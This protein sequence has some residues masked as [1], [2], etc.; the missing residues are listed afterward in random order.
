M[1][2]DDFQT[3]LVIARTLNLHRAADE[4]K[5]TQSAMSKA[6]KRL[7]I[8]YEIP[9]LIRTSH[10]IALTQ[11]GETL[12]ERAAH[13]VNS[14]HDIDSEL[15]D[16]KTA[17]S[18][19][20][21]LGTSPGILDMVISPAIARFRNLQ[22]KV[23]FEVNVQVSQELFT[24]LRAGLLDLAIAPAPDKMPEGLNYDIVTEQAYYVVAR[25]DHPL[26]QRRIKISMLAS[27]EWILPPGDLQMRMWIDALFAEHRL[28]PLRVAIETR[29][30]PALLSPI[31]RQTNLLTVMTRNN[32]E[33]PMGAG[34]S[35]LKVPPWQGR[36]GVFWRRVGYLSPAVRDFLDIVRTLKP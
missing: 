21:R 23:R 9:L 4:L 1:R 14:M 30:L 5:A 25:D 11:A 33:S 35:A 15:T 3:F 7:E 13:L 24:L 2:L 16:I 20:I 31:V 28:G 12:R 19:K 17:A 34:L 27:T 8:Q 6:V 32:L 29:A 18:G 22:P 26:C 10:G 36:L